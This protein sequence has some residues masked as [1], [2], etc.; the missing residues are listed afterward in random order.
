MTYHNYAACEDPVCQRCDDY[1][2]G[3]VDGKSRALFEV[4][5]Q[6]T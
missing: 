6:M 2:A 5:T 4:S 3:Y 1:L